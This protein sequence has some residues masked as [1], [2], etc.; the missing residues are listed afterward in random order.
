MRVY[1]AAPYSTAGL[2]RD[3]HTRLRSRGLTPVSTWAERANGP[4][5]FSMFTVEEIQG[6]AAHNDADLRA[7]DVVLV[8]DHE[9]RGRETYGELRLALEWGK[10]AIYVGKPSLSAWRPGVVRAADVDEAIEQLVRRAALRMR[11]PLARART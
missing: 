9:G 6:H 7:A 10:P 11:R 2:I 5:D 8:I 1:V 4:E 3:L